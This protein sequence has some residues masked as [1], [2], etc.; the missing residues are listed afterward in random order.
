MNKMINKN[1]KLKREKRIISISEI[2]ILIIATFSFA[3]IFH[4]SSTAL[5]NFGVYEN[6]DENNKQNN[7]NNK[8]IQIISL[9]SASLINFIDIIS[10]IPSVSAQAPNQQTSSQ[11]ALKCCPLTKTGAICQDILETEIN[12][13]CDESV[14]ASPTSCENDVRCK[15][16]CCIDDNYGTCSPMS[17]FGECNSNE[18]NIRWVGDKKGDESCVNLNINDNACVKGCCILGDEAIFTTRQACYY[19]AG[20]KYEGEVFN[21]AVKTETECLAQVETIEKGACVFLRTDGSKGCSFISKRECSQNNG[22]PYSGKLCTDTALNT[23]CKPTQKTTCLEGRDEIYFTDTCGN[24]AN[25]YDASRAED[26]TYWNDIINKIDSCGTSSIN[27]NADS[28]TCGNCNRFLGSSCDKKQSTGSDNNYICKNLNCQASEATGNVER[29]NGESWCVYDS[30]IGEGRDVPGSRHWKR[31]CINE[32]VKVEACGDYRSQICVESSIEDATGRKFS[33]ASCK[34]NE[35]IECLSYNS[36]E[37]GPDAMTKIQELCNENEDCFMKGVDVSNNFKFSM[38]VSKYS[39]GFELNNRDKTLSDSLCS[40]AST[41]C[42]AV[43]VK[44]FSGWKWVANKE[45]T[46]PGFADKMNDLCISIGDCGASVNYVGDLTNNYQVLKTPGLT[47]S[48]I[49]KIKE[50]YKTIEGQSAKPK[51]IDEVLSASGT[52][53]NA[54][55]LNEEEIN[56]SKTLGLIKQIGTYAGGAGTVV[57]VISFLGAGS[58]AAGT[59]SAGAGLASTEPIA[60]EAVLASGHT[61]LISGGETF[62]IEGALGGATPVDTVAPA[63]TTTGGSFLGALSGIGVGATAG[64]IVAKIFGLQ[65][66]AVIAVVVGAMIAGGVAGYIGV[67]FFAGAGA[68]AFITTITAALT[69]FIIAVIV[70]VII[71][72]IVLILGIGKVKK[73]HVQFKC[74]PWESPVGGSKCDECNKNPELFPCTKYRCESLGQA[75]SIVNEDTKYS[76]CEEINPGDVAPPIISAG[77]I[78]EGYK[79]ENEIRNEKVDIKTTKD[80]CIPEFTNVEFTL[81]TD[82]VAQCKFGTTDAIYDELEFNEVDGTLYLF[83]HTFNINTPSLDSLDV[84]DLEGDLRE[85][86][87]ATKYYVKCQDVHGIQT[88]RAYVINFCIKQGPDLTAP[89]ILSTYPINGASLKQNTAEVILTMNLNEPAECKYDLENKAYDE[90]QYALECSYDVDEYTTGGYPCFGNLSGLTSG[91]NKWWFKCKDQPWLDYEDNTLVGTRNTNDGYEYKLTVTKNELKIDSV[92][93][94]GDIVSGFVTKVLVDAE[95]KTSG[96]VNNG[97]ASCSLSQTS[98]NRGMIPMLNS[99]SNIHKQPGL[100]YAEGKHKLYFMCVDNVGNTAYKDTNFTVRIDDE[101][102]MVI[103]VLHRNGLE[104]ITNEEA[105]CYYSNSGC[106]FN[107]NNGTSMTN[108]LSTIHH[109]PW[110]DRVVYYIKCEDIFGNVNG[111]CA[112]QVSPYQGK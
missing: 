30:T 11:P 15:V 24:I 103:R 97:V 35:A 25:I 52:P 7:N 2:L 79:F 64:F 22:I 20:E 3:Y 26:E 95:I 45:C 84:R 105:T 65:G 36:Q 87:G 53:L 101:P 29:L 43:K 56:R 40:L 19:K 77:K 93:P 1:I 41:T 82:E 102:P 31:I 70:A 42:T 91:E 33:T 74:L 49:S 38:C 54:E 67:N 94:S 92:K 50:Y 34:V 106:N 88:I 14:T 4:E 28:T 112:I 83:N 61:Q 111:N 55:G 57:K 80:G 12:R 37:T 104:I 66:D 44:K 107:I 72:I 46:Q 69:A 23:T 48:Y 16:G 76:R 60:Y 39:R 5:V 86:L 90:M 68:G 21:S 89:R 13:L 8:D 100:Q 63:A 17:T 32:E 98:F 58:S 10:I 51:S 71:A 27:G 85:R 73:I 110:N 81:D 108:V 18:G 109:A 59:G 9:L 47:P 96:G 6:K 75:C 78:E 62:P 99:F